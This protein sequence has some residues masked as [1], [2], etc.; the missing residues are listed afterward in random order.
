MRLTNNEVVNLYENLRAAGQKTLPV[1]IAF[2]FVKD[3]KVLE[4]YYK[5]IIETRDTIVRNV[6]E[7]QDDGSVVVPQDKIEE[8]N[9]SL[10]ELGTIETDLNLDMVP[11]SALTGTSWTLDEINGIYPIINGEV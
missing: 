7:P 6:G 10:E 1:Q 2:S 5:A 9:K 4:P 8:T 11:L 3:T